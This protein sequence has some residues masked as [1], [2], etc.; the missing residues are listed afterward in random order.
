MKVKQQQLLPFLAELQKYHRHMRKKNSIESGF[1]LL[2]ILV[3]VS[4]FSIAAIGMLPTFNSFMGRNSH[5]HVQA[6]ALQA[7]EQV[8]DSMRILDPATLPA[9][10]NNGGTNITIGNRSFVVTTYFCEQ[11][12]LCNSTLTRHLR[13]QV[14]YQNEVIFNV[15][16]VFTSLR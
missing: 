9:S 7:A 4:I 5:S 8:L 10:G 15:Q 1:S 14:S 3:S 16:T 6:S 13:V 12:S 2:E 11:S